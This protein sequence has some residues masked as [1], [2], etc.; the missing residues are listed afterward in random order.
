M[1]IP[2]ASVD[3]QDPILQ[4]ASQIAMS[5]DTT[6]D[7]PSPPTSSFTPYQ[8]YF[9]SMNSTLLLPSNNSLP[10]VH[11]SSAAPPLHSL[12]CGWI[13]TIPPELS[14]ASMAICSHLSGPAPLTSLPHMRE[15]SDMPH[16]WQWLGSIPEPAID[17]ADSL[18]ELLAAAFSDSTLDRSRT[19]TPPS[20]SGLTTPSTLVIDQGSSP[21]TQSAMTN[22]P[23]TKRRRHRRR[24]RA[25]HRKSHSQSSSRSQSPSRSASPPRYPPTAQPPSLLS[26]LSIAPTLDPKELE[27][28]RPVR[29][30]RAGSPFRHPGKEQKTY[31]CKTH[32]DPPDESSDNESIIVEL[33]GSE[34]LERDY[35]DP[36]PGE[37]GVRFNTPF[38][39]TV[40]AWAQ[41]PSE[42]HIGFSVR[43]NMKLRYPKQVRMA[44]LALAL[45]PW[46]LDARNHNGRVSVEI[47]SRGAYEFLNAVCGCLVWD[48][49]DLLRDIKL[50]RTHYVATGHMVQYGI[51]SPECDWDDPHRDYFFRNA[52]PASWTYNTILH[53]MVR[54][55]WTDRDFV[56]LAAAARRWCQAYCLPAVHRFVQ[57]PPV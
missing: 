5:T 27:V 41:A 8:S 49:D 3:S 22:P 24:P 4:L 50:I 38:W 19:D 47:R 42:V 16:F 9:P 51:H 28:P 44:R 14:G 21:P 12:L 23:S 46:A 20:L 30:L 15:P 54:Y 17:R 33:D 55:G 57:I 26:R 32:A 13:S 11:E 53:W 43:K 2:L 10:L 31:G 34:S 18:R 37:P 40:E 1:S 48:W 6:S 7:F 25:G 29:N 56:L 35:V 45:A 52:A 39:E 36:P